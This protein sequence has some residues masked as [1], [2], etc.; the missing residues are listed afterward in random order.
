MTGS[1]NPS[2]CILHSSFLMNLDLVER[3]ANA[4]LYE[5]YILYPYRPSAVKNQQRWNFGALCPAAYS[6]AQG[7]TEAWTMQTEVL[8]QGDE[9]ATLDLKVRF[10]HLLARE[11]GVPTAACSLRIADRADSEMQALIS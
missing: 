5:G 11:I 7:G 3:I 9:H 2:F 6:Q 4:V 1:F 8:V 10:L